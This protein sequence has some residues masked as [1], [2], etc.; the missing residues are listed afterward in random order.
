MPTRDEKDKFSVMIE[1]LTINEGVTHMEAI[2]DYCSKTGLEV[3]V[4]ATLVNANLKSKLES[5]ARA[6]RYLGKSSA[7]PI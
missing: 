2:V 7:L 5:E 6:L 1:E 4:A 3:E